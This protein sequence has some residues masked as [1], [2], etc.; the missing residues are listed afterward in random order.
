MSGP[1]FALVESNTTGT[2]RDFAEAA[3]RHGLRPVLL[4]ASP[5]RYPYVEE[6]RLDVRAV[7][8]TCLAAVESAC[9]SLLSDGLAGVTSSSDSYVRT[10]ALMAGRLGLPGPDPPAIAR[11]RDKAVQRTWLAER[12][13]PVPDFA[14]CSTPAQAADAARNLSVPVVVKPVHGTGSRGV[15][16][17]A[18][19]DAAG[20]WADELLA[21]PDVPAVL[22][23]R[24]VVGAEYS[25][26]VLDG[27]AVGV[28]RKHLGAPPHFV[29]TG[30]DFP[31]DVTEPA[32][33][34]LASAAVEA[35]RLIGL[36]AGP[37]HVELRL[38]AGGQPWLIEINPRLAGGLI[39]RLVRYA[40]GRD[41]VD[42][43]IASAAGRPRSPTTRRERFASIRFVV[44]S[45][46]GVVRGVTGVAEARAVPGVVDVACAVSAGT[47]IRVEHS[48][49]DRVGHVIGVADSA[50]EAIRIAERALAGI[51]IPYRDSAPMV[52]RQAEQ[53][54]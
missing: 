12:G 10:A 54:V 23:E 30:H 49:A 4:A 11:C 2:G 43:V 9:R 53:R 42:E 29:E 39:P 27:D 20:A 41:L 26:E 35:A 1:W 18:G 6:L 40:T 7:D 19:P 22:V 5:G 33:A 37:A 14:V 21:L 28:T 32:A 47:R 17:C 51:E 48:F 38:A 46:G 50:A 44:P 25:V 16:A 13:F 24:E 31:A 45:R 8:T 34:R 3:R 15:L 36:S 52:E